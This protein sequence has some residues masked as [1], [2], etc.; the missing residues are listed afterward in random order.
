MELEAKQLEEYK[1]VN[2]NM[3]HFSNMRIAVLTISLAMNGV[4]IQSFLQQTNTFILIG[5]ILMGL[6]STVA[7]LI[8]E[9]RVTYFYLFYQARAMELEVILELKQHLRPRPR[10]FFNATNATKALYI[11][12]AVFW[13]ILVFYKLKF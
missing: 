7:F 11:A 8:F 3:R 6:I 4:L 1:E 12:I 13:L 9:N 10:P 2:S 5:L